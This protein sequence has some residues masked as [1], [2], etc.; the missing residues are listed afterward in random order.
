MSKM[1]DN[2]A[3]V[4]EEAQPASADKKPSLFVVREQPVG[5]AS[6][7]S[8]GASGKKA[9]AIWGVAAVLLAGL[10]ASYFLGQR[11]GTAGSAA[12]RM[13]MEPRPLPAGEAVA[14]IRSGQLGEA[15]NALA[16]QL[17]A[18]PANSAARLNQAYLL[19]ELGQLEEAEA[20]LRSLLLSR[21]KDPLLL[22]NLGALLL[23]A[24]RVAEAEA[25]LRKAVELD[26][27]AFEA[28]AN[29]AGALERRRDWNGAMKIFEE[30]LA[31]G[32]HGTRAALIRERVR[33]LR[34][35]AAAS[36]TPKEKL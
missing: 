2:L 14:L 6:G 33:R 35:L 22:N 28:R 30:I 19:K 1:M 8:G 26:P 24:G 15:K 34:S 32:D 18:Q 21:P 29:L 36:L 20:I 9:F 17:R 11:A 25:S 12:E 5:S 16:S 7:G 10:G 13:A 31:S 27:R 3:R 23:R 4:Q